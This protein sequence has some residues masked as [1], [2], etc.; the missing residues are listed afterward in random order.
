MSLIFSGLVSAAG[1]S[2]CGVTTPA[3]YTSKGSIKQGDFTYNQIIAFAVAKPQTAKLSMFVSAEDESSFDSVNFL[4]PIATISGAGPQGTDK[5]SGV[6]TLTQ[7]LSQ[8]KKTLTLNYLL[9]APKE[10]QTVVLSVLPDKKSVSAPLGGYYKLD[11]TYIIPL[12]LSVANDAQR[13]V[14]K[15]TVVSGSL[16]LRG[17]GGGCGV[18]DFESF[19]L[20]LSFDT[21]EN[22]V[23]KNAKQLIQAAFSGEGLVK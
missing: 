6:I 4:E 21:P 1:A 9:S 5:K 16:V 22:A 7:A 19:Q 8:G 13:I 10:W 15:A 23:K 17:Q 12:K 11:Y 14:K 2:A 3:A 20:H 18:E